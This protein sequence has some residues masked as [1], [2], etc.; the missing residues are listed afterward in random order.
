MQRVA[1]PKLIV[2]SGPSG[3]GKTTL[4]DEMLKD[5]RLVAS[6]SCTTRPPRPGEAEGRDYWFLSRE[7]Y[8]RR[9]RAGAFLEHA[10]VYGNLYGTPR[11]PVEAWMREGRCP[12]LEID[13]QG[14]DQVR[15]KGLPALY[16]FI[17]PRSLE[18]LR[19]RLQ[20]RRTEDEAAMQRRL[21]VAAREMEAASRYD[22][23]VVN[24]NLAEAVAALRDILEKRVFRP[25]A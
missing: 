6:V 14:A 17:A 4:C 1:S 12:L 5:P 19:E 20:R 25:V 15:T 22:A 7:E 10:E 23:V 24:E 11:A 16:L 13:V 18:V 9:I 2:V 8:E 21:A 3:V